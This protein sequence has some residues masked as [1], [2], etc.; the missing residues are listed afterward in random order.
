M[1]YY[2]MLFDAVRSIFI[3]DNRQKHMILYKV[4]YIHIQ[5]ML[6]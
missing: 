3:D 2:Y 1:T 5:R 6:F 4:I